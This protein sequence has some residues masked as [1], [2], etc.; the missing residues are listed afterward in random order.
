MVFDLNSKIEINQKP[1]IFCLGEYDVFDRY[2]TV[3]NPCR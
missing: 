3:E 2:I 1:I